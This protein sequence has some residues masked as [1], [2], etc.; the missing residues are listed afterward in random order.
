MDEQPRHLRLETYYLSKVQDI[1]DH[2]LG[3]L[4]LA[5]PEADR[6]GRSEDWQQI[7]YSPKGQ[8]GVLFASLELI[9]KTVG[10]ET[11][12]FLRLKSDQLQSTFDAADWQKFADIV[13]E[14]D[15]A[16]WLPRP[17]LKAN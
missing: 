16:S 15:T 4:E 13:H 2:I 10:E 12:G 17:K 8:F 7:L 14:L 11:Y 3:M 1:K 9:R 5:L 6:T